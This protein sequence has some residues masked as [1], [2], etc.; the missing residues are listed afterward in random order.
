MISEK[1][2][3]KYCSEDITLIENYD[4]AVTDL[5]QI[6]DC[7]HRAEILPCGRYRVEDLQK[8]DLYW[9]RPASELIFLPHSV[10]Y[11]MHL[12]G[13]SFT[14]GLL[15]W[16]KGKKGGRSWNKG[17]PCAEETKAKISKTKTGRHLSEA[18]RKAIGDSRRGSRHPNYGKHLSESTRS[19]I[20]RAKTSS[21][22]GKVWCNNGV[23][24]KFVNPADVPNGWTL[25]RL[26][27]MKWFTNG[28][29]DVRRKEC[30]E[31]FVRGRKK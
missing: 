1:H 30:P 9:H 16:N 19:K 2:I 25:G 6:W 3:I 31:G 18:H 15:P 29:I 17:I 10:H 24:A 21:N 12:K 23:S 5:T 4:L 22:T 14:K 20:S 26:P 11:S 7:H 8:H 13:N 28:K 27:S